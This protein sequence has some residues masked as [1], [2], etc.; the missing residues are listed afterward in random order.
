MDEVL[1]SIII[2][3]KPLFMP[4]MSACIHRSVLIGYIGACLGM[5][6]AHGT[7]HTLYLEAKIYHWIEIK[8]YSAIIVLR[9]DDRYCYEEL[10]YNV[11]FVMYWLQLC[12]P[13]CAAGKACV[14]LSVILTHLLLLHCMYFLIS[15]L[16]EMIN[17]KFGEW[18]KYIIMIIQIDKELWL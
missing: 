5:Q 15:L 18:Y 12:C 13:L 10:S 16:I 6:H 7:F 1:T 8:Y 9:N 14:L 17:L 3:G 11:F 2:N 4:W